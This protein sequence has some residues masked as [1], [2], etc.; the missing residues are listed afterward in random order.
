M[1]RQRRIV[2]A[3]AAALVLLALLG[4]GTT[5]PTHYHS[6]LAPPVSSGAAAKVVPAPSVQFEVLQVTVPVQVDVPQIVVRLPDHSLSVLEHE[7]WIAPLG[8]EIRALVTQRVE[9]TLLQGAPVAVAVA[10]R[11]WRVR[12]D[13]QRFDSMLGRAASVQALWSLQAA[14]GGAAALR[15]QASYEQ[16]VG[17]GV[18]ALTAGHRAL[19]EQLG[20]AIGRALKV[21]ASGGTPACG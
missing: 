3:P 18:G 6:L 2:L 4:C 1:T 13:V 19:F 5:P 20:D 16:P 11:S 12:L 10:D 8:D 9:Q 21:A 15:C 17:A 14:G 7:R